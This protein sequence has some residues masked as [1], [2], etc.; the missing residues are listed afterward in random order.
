M[1]NPLW[2]F[3][4][5]QMNRCIDGWRAND[6]HAANELVR[7]AQSRFNLLAAQ[8]YRGYPNIRKIGDVDDVTQRGWMRLLH[9]LKQTRPTDTKGFFVLVNVHLTRVLLDMAREAKALKNQT[10]SLEVV[11]AGV[12][13]GSRY[14]VTDADAEKE[15]KDIEKWE[16]FHVGVLQL[17]QELKE[18]VCLRFYDDRP[19]SE[20]ATILG[21]HE[22]TIRR[23]WADACLLIRA[24]VNGADGPEANAGPD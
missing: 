8:M 11:G 13:S 18:V 20:I 16:R 4:T 17:P 12:G 19:F 23:W 7:R 1:F 24:Y 14:P 10:V 21:R 15:L 9:T 22:R 2:S 6:P 3:L 5:S